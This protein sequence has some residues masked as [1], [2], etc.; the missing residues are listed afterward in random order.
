MSAITPYQQLLLH[1]GIAA[2]NPM[3]QEAIRTITT[4]ENTWIKAPTGSGK[5]LA[6]LFPLLP[7]L[8]PQREG[9]QVLI[10]SPARELALQIGDVFRRLQSGFGV[11]VFYGGHRM[12]SELDQLRQP[13]AVVVATPGRLADHL[14]HGRI[15]TSNLQYLVLDEFDKCQELGFSEDINFILSRLPSLKKRICVSATGSPD[16]TAIAG[17]TNPQKVEYVRHEEASGLTMYHVPVSEE[18][19]VTSLF[20]LLSVIGH[21]TTLVFC[22]RRDDVDKLHQDMLD[23]GLPCTRFHGGVEQVDRERAIIRIRHGSARILITTDLAARG[24]DIPEV[25]HV[26]HFDLSRKEEEFQ[27]RNGRTARM[28][29]L[30][31]AYLLSPDKNTLPDYVQASVKSFVLPKVSLPPIPEWETLYVNLGRKQKIRKLD[32]VGWL[33]Q[34]GGLQPEELGRVDI[35]DDRSYA[36]VPRDK[37][38]G[39]IQ[40]LQGEPL[41][42]KKGKVLITRE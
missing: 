2:L 32:V 15:N 4:A 42:K 37:A 20:Q 27:H 17:F 38:K 12:R 13:P 8:K 40:L 26:V 5:T 19:R 23:R 14:R 28:Q 39:V 35:M 29:A 6:Y 25:R 24:I 1:A 7:L 36:A 34:K 33:L 9:C 10:L 3:Q 22:T 21:E 30:G 16:E 11:T 18:S 31:A 41:K